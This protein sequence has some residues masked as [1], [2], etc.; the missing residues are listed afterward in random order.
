[1][2]GRLITNSSRVIVL[3]MNTSLVVHV[4][5]GY[6][7]LKAGQ[8][9]LFWNDN[10]ILFEQGTAFLNDEYCQSG[11]RSS[12][13]TWKN[14]ADNLSFWIN[15]C[16]AANLDWQHASRDDLIDYLDGLN[17]AISPHTHQEYASGTIA[18]RIE[19]TIAFCDYGRRKGFYSGDILSDDTLSKLLAQLD[20]TQG[21]SASSLVPARR[22]KKNVIRP[23]K[24]TALR[25]FLVQMGPTPSER[26]SEDQRPSRD[27][28]MADWGWAVGLR[29]SEILG[30][31]CYQL[32]ALVPDEDAPFENQAITVRGKGNYERNVAVPNWLV[33][34]TIAYIEEER[35]EAIKAGGQR[36]PTDAVF[37][38]GIRS[39]RP[40][41]PITGRRFE[42]IVKCACLRA[43]LTRLKL[44]KDVESG[45][46]TRVP[47][48]DHCVHDLRH[49]YAVLT[50]WTEVQN[51]N[52]EPWKIIQAQ[53]GHARLETTIRTYL[54][55]VQ[56]F[57]PRGNQDIRTLAGL[58]KPSE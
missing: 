48:A 14:V 5:E 6:E 40:G 51:G 50:Y 25:A 42:E 29:L 37:V 11:A 27:R 9:S 34:D 13:R 21:E 8:P 16:L 58:G 31:G 10:R 1:M 52:A 55:Y 23:F 12:P 57:G 56:L 43:G 15:W 39:R 2:A 17:T 36:R 44:I 4:T 24:P 30:L 18:P 32:L 20:Q 54:R 22:P 49:T 7:G 33:A 3:S 38:S 28:I 26:S 41:L 19:T 45:T 47:V 46:S 35:A 53:L